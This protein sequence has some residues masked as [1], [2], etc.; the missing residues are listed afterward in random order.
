MLRIAVVDDEREQ[1]DNPI[2]IK[3]YIYSTLIIAVLRS[4]SRHTDLRYIML[5]IFF[6]NNVSIICIIQETQHTN[7]NNF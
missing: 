1:S 7:K 6:M 5:M 3:C 2:E 4:V